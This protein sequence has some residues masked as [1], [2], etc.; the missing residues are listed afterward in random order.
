MLEE[1][2][3]VWGRVGGCEEGTPQE[4]EWRELHQD[5]RAGLLCGIK[6]LHVPLEQNAFDRTHAKES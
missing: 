6:T 5:G 4:E 3:E 2:T 1:S